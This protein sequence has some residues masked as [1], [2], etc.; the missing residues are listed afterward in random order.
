MGAH[1][2]A[3]SPQLPRSA[4]RAA[5]DGCIGGVVAT[6]HA[7]A[8]TAAARRSRANWPSPRRRDSGATH[9]ILPSNEGSSALAP[10]LRCLLGHELRKVDPHT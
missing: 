6:E 5:A 9:G 4:V 7:T 2:P 1:A 8:A 10:R 3:Q